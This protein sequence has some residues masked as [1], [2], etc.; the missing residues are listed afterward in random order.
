M[1]RTKAEGLTALLPNPIPPKRNAKLESELFRPATLRTL[2]P[3]Y[4]GVY[5]TQVRSTERGHEVFVLCQKHLRGAPTA[6][7]LGG[8]EVPVTV[9][10]ELP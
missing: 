7:D 4:H 2:L 10:A 1:R 6:I 8:V 9:C 3:N 5:F